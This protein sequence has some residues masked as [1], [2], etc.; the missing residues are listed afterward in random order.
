VTITGRF[1]L[2]SGL[3]SPRAAPPPPRKKVPPDF[4]QSSLLQPKTFSPTESRSHHKETFSSLWLRRIASSLWSTTIR[5]DWFTDHKNNNFN[6]K[7]IIA[8]ATI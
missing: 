8:S 3:S 4:H 7:D 2:D 6:K 1:T 5:G